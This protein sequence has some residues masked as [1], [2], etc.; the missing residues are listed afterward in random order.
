MIELL[1][2]ITVYGCS[3][4]TRIRSTYVI[5]GSTVPPQRFDFFLRFPVTKS[6]EPAIA[7]L[8][9]PW[10]DVSFNLNPSTRRQQSF[11]N[12]NPAASDLAA[13]TVGQDLFFVCPLS[14]IAPDWPT[15][16]CV[17]N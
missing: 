17:V 5:D 8:H 16:V 9:G 4:Y 7:K 14:Q 12:D 10:Y 3:V 2:P 15:C 11:I 13:A 1:F 6:D